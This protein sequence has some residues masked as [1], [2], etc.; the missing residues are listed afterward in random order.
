PFI[1]L[2]R[3]T[4]SGQSRVYRVT[5]LRTN[6]VHCRESAGTGPVVLNVVPVTGAAIRIGGGDQ[7]ENTGVHQK[8]DEEHWN[9]TQGSKR[10]AGGYE[11]HTRNL[12]G[13][14][15]LDAPHEQ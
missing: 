8:V 3:H 12:S 15:H 6:G 10:Q 4:P 1:Y 9:I 13:L 7:A 11:P 14:Q 5:Q 2:N